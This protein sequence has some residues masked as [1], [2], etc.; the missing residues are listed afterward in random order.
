MMAKK[1]PLQTVPGTD[2]NQY[3]ITIEDAVNSTAMVTAQL[4][5]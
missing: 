5:Q 3:A 1:I 2:G 4:Y